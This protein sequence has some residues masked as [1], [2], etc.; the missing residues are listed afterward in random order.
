V[1][2]SSYE[3]I[4]LLPAAGGTPINLTND[5]TNN[6]FEETWSPNGDEIA[7]VASPISGTFKTDIYKVNIHTLVQT[8]L[9]TDGSSGSPIWSPDGTHIAFFDIAGLYVMNPDGSNNRYLPTPGYPQDIAWSLDGRRIAFRN[10]A[11]IS[12]S[13]IYVIDVATGNVQRLT[14]NAVDDGYPAWRPD[15]WK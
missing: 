8:R 14:N 2:T 7:F 13:E 12:E 10:L 6:Y 4:F 15:T 1:N 11:N 5:P 9:T 3:S